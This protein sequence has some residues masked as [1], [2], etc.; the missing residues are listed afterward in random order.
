MKKIAYCLYGQ[1]R[2]YE[3]GAIIIN[4]LIQKYKGI[5][6]FDF[7]FHT[8]FDP[9]LINTYYSA[10]AHRYINKESLLIKEN[11]IQE[12]IAIYNPKSYEYEKP[13]IFDTMYIQKSKMFLSTRPHDQIN[14]NNTLSNLYSK[15]KLGC[16]FEKYMKNKNS[17]YEF[18]ITSRFDITKTI[19]IDLTTI[20]PLK[21]YN[22][23]VLPRIHLCDHILICGCEL[24]QKYSNAYNNIENIMNN[25]RIQQI[26]DYIGAGYCFVI[27]SIITCNMI[28]YY[29]GGIINSIVFTKDIPN[30][31]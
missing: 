20:N 6:E 30:F 24:F 4:D 26:V 1:P 21:I 12:L 9:E 14:I 25:Q 13:M 22:M 10:S 16:I 8:W 29:D 15:Y 7:F 27:E 2:N 17:E 23:N 31:V 19:T 11:T 18:V 5:Y 28:Y 3:D